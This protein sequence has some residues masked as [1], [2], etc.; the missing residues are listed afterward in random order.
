MMAFITHFCR[1]HSDT[2]RRL[3]IGFFVAFMVFT[4]V[5]DE[6]VVRRA[7]ILPEENAGYVV[8]ADVDFEHVW[9]Y[10]LLLFQEER[11]NIFKRKNRK[12][13]KQ[14]KQME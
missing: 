14:S 10:F 7:E 8:N 12:K 3:A 1:K 5:A 6:A 11:R 2:N 13:R 9:A 4:A